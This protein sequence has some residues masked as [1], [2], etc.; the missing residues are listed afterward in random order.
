MDIRATLAAQ[1]ERFGALGIGGWE[2]LDMD[3]LAGEAAKLGC[4]DRAQLSALMLT[5][6]GESG[7]G[8]VYSFD[9]AGMAPG[10][11]YVEFLSNAGR[12]SGGEFSPGD[13]SQRGPLSGANAPKERVRFMWRGKSYSYN[14]NVQGDWFDDGLIDYV[15]DALQ[16]A[17]VRK[18]FFGLFDGAQGIIL[19]YNTQEWLEGLI[20]AIQGA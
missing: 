15:N 18:R 9:A 13:V 5:R 11:M 17:G 1:A 8:V 2:R 6:L 7:S 19:M 16:R 10:H 4:S 14:A 3:A 12:I 20:G